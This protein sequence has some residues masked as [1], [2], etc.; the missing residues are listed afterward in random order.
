MFCDA[1]T[2]A[3]EAQQ[4]LD[5]IL[6]MYRVEHDA[7]EQ[8]IVRT[9]AH[10]KLRKTRSAATMDQF[11]TWLLLQQGQHLP[12]GPMGKAISCALDNWVLLPRFVKSEQIAVDSNASERTLH[13]VA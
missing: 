3:P 1:L 6:H 2:T 12:K 5:L 9:P 10:L 13:V 7:K 8:G 11:H 4:A